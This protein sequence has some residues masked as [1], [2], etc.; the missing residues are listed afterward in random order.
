MSFQTRAP[1]KVERS[2]FG[3]PSEEKL[4]GGCG[5]ETGRAGSIFGNFKFYENL[6]LKNGHEPDC[7]LMSEAHL[8]RIKFFL[9]GYAVSLGFVCFFRN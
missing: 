4:P 5:F 3:S 7:V 8:A 6:L 1:A 9:T 2:P